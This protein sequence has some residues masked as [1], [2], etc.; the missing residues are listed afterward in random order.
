MARY[1][2]RKLLEELVSQVPGL[3]NGPAHLNRT[4]FSNPPEKDWEGQA[5]L[6]SGYYSHWYNVGIQDGLSVSSDL[7]IGWLGF[8]GHRI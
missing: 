6:N 8:Y 3:D 4:L 7:C 5:V 1:R 2:N